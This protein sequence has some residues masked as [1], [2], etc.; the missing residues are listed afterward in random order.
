MRLL[1]R[2]SHSR[3]VLMSARVAHSQGAGLIQGGVI[4]ALADTVA[5]YMLLDELGPRPTCTSIGFKF[6]FLHPPGRAE[7]ICSPLRPP[8]NAGAVS[9]LALSTSNKPAA[10]LPRDCSAS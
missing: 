1:E 9:P 3:R 10:W 4:S 6:N 5:V 2:G 7:L 8:R